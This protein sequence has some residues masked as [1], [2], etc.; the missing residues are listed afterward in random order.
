MPWRTAW[1][2]ESGRFRMPWTQSA[3]G[4]GGSRLSEA[5]PPGPSTVGLLG[6]V[7]E[8]RG[9]PIRLIRRLARHYGDAACVTLGGRPLIA[10]FGPIYHRTVL[11]EQQD[12]F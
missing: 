7:V 3:R 1:S 4:T 12:S 2:I 11:L 9:D 8:A 5:L 10:G 6:H